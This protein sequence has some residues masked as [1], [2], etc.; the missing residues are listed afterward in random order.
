M[1]PPHSRERGGGFFVPA[2]RQ[3]RGRPMAMNSWIFSETPM[4]AAQLGDM[5]ARMGVPAAA[6]QLESW[7]Q[8]AGASMRREAPDIVLIAASR[9]LPSHLELLRGLRAKLDATIAV[10][11]T[12]P[13]HSAVL[14]A[15]R[16]GADDFIDLAGD[17]RG[18]L[19]SLIAR[20]RTE[21]AGP[22]SRRLITVI[23]SADPSDASFLA[24]NMAVAMAQASGSC[25][26]LDFH[27]R[28]GDLAALLG[29]APRHTLADLVRQ[30]GEI[31]Q[32]VFEQALTS[33]AS[34]V[35]L[36]AA[37]T[38]F[39]K[40]GASNPHVLQQL[41]SMARGGGPNVV[42]NAEQAEQADEIGLLTTSS[43]ILL[44]TRLD[45]VSLS[46][47]KHHMAFMHDR[48]VAS[49]AAVIVALGVGRRAEVPAKD[50]QRVLGATAVE[51]IP[52]DSLAHMVSVNVGEPIVRQAPKSL[53]SRAICRIAA[54][55]LE[56]ARS[57]MPAATARPTLLSLARRG[58]AGPG[59]SSAASP[60]MS[61]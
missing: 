9:I 50:V 18:E 8:E 26:L 15:I 1:P 38:L 53:T 2:E 11:S 41:V 43:R 37:P 48:G 4:L 59:R 20:L 57:P 39:S 56:G 52:E 35:R 32:A 44:A 5:L 27:L 16:A 45:L 49:E 33:H 40:L 10:L 17:V 46:R 22:G 6:K 14:Q 13:H 36:L 47:A 21:S 55:L 42:V 51:C 60:A 7:E 3:R 23:P 54:A 25:E 12:I 19:Q 30:P 31:D 29:V 34:G 24:A 28:G 58:L 61:S